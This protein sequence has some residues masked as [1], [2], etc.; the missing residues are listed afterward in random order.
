MLVSMNVFFDHT[1]YPPL[2]IRLKP[3]TV[4][5]G[6]IGAFAM[7]NFKLGEVVVKSEWFQ[8]DNIMSIE[9]YNKLDP[10]RHELLKAH[11]TIVDDKLFIQ[12]DLNFLRPINYFNHSCSPNIGF[13]EQDNY[14]AITPIKKGEEF[15]L[16]Y[17]FLNTNPDYRMECRCGSAACRRIIT[18]T[19]WQNADFVAR[20][21]NYFASTV[22]VKV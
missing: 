7:Q 10:D 21:R 22:R 1:T 4:V 19:E 8:D 13:D 11:S 3:S 9:E 17:S 18:G 12:A 5:A 15:L 20:N 14:V 16:D 2:F 6:E